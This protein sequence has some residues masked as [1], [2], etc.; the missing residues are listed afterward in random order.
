MIARTKGPPFSRFKLLEVVPTAYNLPSV[1]V[2]KHPT[3][4]H[5]IRK[6]ATEMLLHV[7]F[8]RLPDNLR[9]GLM[10]TA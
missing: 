3:K 10:G 8:P 9:A 6:R 5:V 4:G 7:F 2:L 1:L